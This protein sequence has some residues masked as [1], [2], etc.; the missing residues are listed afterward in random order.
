MDEIFDVS[1]VDRPFCDAVGTRRSTSRSVDWVREQLAAANPDN[2]ELEGGDP[3]D[4]DNQTGERLFNYH[5][6]MDKVVKVSDRA[7]NVD[8]VGTADELIKQVMKRQKELRRDEEARYCSRKVAVPGVANTTASQTAGVGAWIGVKKVVEG[9][10]VASNTS[11]RGAGSAD[12]VLSQDGTG[13]GYPTTAATNAANQTLTESDIK[14]M[15]R[16]AFENGG[17]PTMAMSTPT[18]IELLSDYL[19]TS[20]ARVATLQSNAPQGNRT[21]NGTGGGQSGG[22]VTAQGAVNILVTNFGTLELVPNRFQPDVD[23]G[24]AA[25]L[26][27]IDP[28]TWE[29][30]YLQGYETKPLARTGTAETRQITVDAALVCLNPEANAV[31]AD[32]DVTAAVTP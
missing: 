32:I 1:P 30:S 10:E 11:A 22:G 17:E 5:Q 28:T 26:Y 4:D 27:L 8:T 12:P 6:I 19:F 31:V 20:S 14:N 9:S 21:D 2:A 18:V 7:S 13:G 29:R 15:M 24:V 16:A 25:D 23:A 3:A